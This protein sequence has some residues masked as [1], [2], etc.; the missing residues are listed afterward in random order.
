MLAC[1]CS[2][3]SDLQPPECRVTELSRLVLRQDDAYEHGR[4]AGLD[5]I[6]KEVP[7]EFEAVAAWWLAGYEEGDRSYKRQ[8]PE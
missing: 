4:C 1:P 3:L 5:R 7:P 2:G 8:V 6:P